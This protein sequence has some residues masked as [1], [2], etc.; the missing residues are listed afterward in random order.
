[1]GP[2]VWTQEQERGVREALSGGQLRTIG[3]AV[4]RRA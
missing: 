2:E 1:M 3:E 4:G